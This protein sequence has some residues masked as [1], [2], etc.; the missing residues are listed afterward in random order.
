MRTFSG[1][2]EE[3]SDNPTQFVNIALD[4]CD[5]QRLMIL[6][7][8]AAK[9]VE[10][11]CDRVDGEL[12]NTGLV[13]SQILEYALTKE[14]DISKYDKYSA[15]YE[16]SCFLKTATDEELIDVGFMV[17]TVLSY[18][19]PK[20]ENFVSEFVRIIDTVTTPLLARNSQLL[21]CRLSL[22]LGYYI[23]ILYKEDQATFLGVLKLLVESLMSDKKALAN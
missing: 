15:V 16:G 20:K 18:S 5:R 4:T 7:C 9:L 12:V 8:Q 13:C 17:L 11:M 22:F 14:G 10:T 1:E 19:L 23:D 3:M 21:E 6:K 2:L